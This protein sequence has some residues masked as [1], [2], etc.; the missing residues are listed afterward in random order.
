VRYIVHA[1]LHL[2]GFDDTR[3]IA[4]RKMKR[5]ENRLL[6]ELTSH[7]SLTRLANHRSHPQPLQS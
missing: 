2:L 1:I 4:R 7:I 3:P 6:R 5:E